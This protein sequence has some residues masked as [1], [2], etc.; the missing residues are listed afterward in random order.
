MKL[1][2]FLAGM[3]LFFAGTGAALADNHYDIVA[4][5]DVNGD[6]TFSGSMSTTAPF[7][8]SYN[9]S[10]LDFRINDTVDG[11]M[12]DAANSTIAIETQGFLFSAKDGSSSFELTFYPD[13]NYYSDYLVAGHDT[14]GNSGYFVFN[15]VS[16]V[17]EPANA[18]LL[19]VGLGA[20]GLRARRSGKPLTA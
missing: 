12:Y 4:I 11:V 14:V 15:E 18:A 2:T 1:A 8:L 7:S 10:V 16:A 17:P 3:T 13:G 20:L 6:A 19:L 5:D 9:F